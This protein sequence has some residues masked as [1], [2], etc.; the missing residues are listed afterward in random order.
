MASLGFIWQRPILSVETCKHTEE[1]APLT[2]CFLSSKQQI[3]TKE[4]QFDKIV[5][6]GI[7]VNAL[8]TLWTCV[9]V[10][11]YVSMYVSE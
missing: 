3:L 1:E 6:F 8:R 4:L 11:K 10:Y 5:K 2:F 7:P 9:Y